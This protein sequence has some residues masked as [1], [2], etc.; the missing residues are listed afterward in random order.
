VLVVDRDRSVDTYSH[1]VLKAFQT[2]KDL[3]FPLLYSSVSNQN[4]PSIGFKGAVGD[5]LAVDG[6]MYA[7]RIILFASSS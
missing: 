7:S 1:V 6:G 5:I 2:F 3:V 4:W